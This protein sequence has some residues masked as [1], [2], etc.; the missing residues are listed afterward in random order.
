M[1]ADTTLIYIMLSCF[2]LGVI[3]PQL[4]VSYQLYKYEKSILWGLSGL[5]LWFGLNIYMY[6]I[7]KLERKSG[8]KFERLTAQQRKTW[9]SLYLCVMM[10]YLVLFTIFGWITSPSNSYF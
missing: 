9:R 10:Q 5:I 3:F 6:Q 8:M 7:V 2:I 1:E 4:Y